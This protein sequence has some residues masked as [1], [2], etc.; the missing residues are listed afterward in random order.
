MQRAAFEGAEARIE[1]ERLPTGKM[2]GANVA[3]VGNEVITFRELTQAIRDWERDHLQPDQQLTPEEK[4]Q[5]AA[6]AL[7]RLIERSLVL[8]DARR[9]FGKKKDGWKHFEKYIDDRW[10]EEELPTLLRKYQVANEYEL[11][12]KMAEQGL[13]LDHIK[14]TYK[15]DR[16]ESEYLYLKLH[17]KLK[18]GLLEMREYYARHLH[19]YD[20]PASVTWREIVVTIPEGGDRAAARRKAEALLDRLRR[21]EDFARLA[22]AESQGPTAREAGLWKEMEPGSHK[23][24]AV[25]EALRR[26]RLQEISPLIEGPDGFHILRVE[27]RREAGP[28]SFVEVQDQVFDT[29]RNRNFQR[30]RQAFLDKLR[31]QTFV[32][33]WFDGTDSDPNQARPEGQPAER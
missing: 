32:E 26:L 4:N 11:Q 14:E 30:E 5:L 12:V 27:A 25:N 9:E 13:S 24:P 19:D 6:A 7:T 10:R 33:T 29:L 2:L 3:R 20:R 21:G 1:P 16:Q 17:A 28:A 8:Q 31:R 22:R 18:P 23:V 15:L